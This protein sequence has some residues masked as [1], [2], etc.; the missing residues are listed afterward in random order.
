MSVYDLERVKLPVLTGTPLKLFTALLKAPLVGPPLL[1]KLVA[2][3]G[4][5]KLLKAQLSQEPTFRPLV[6]PNGPAPEGSVSEELPNATG[7][8][9]IRDYQRAYQS[10]EL[11]PSDVAEATLTAIQ[12]SDA[13][14]RPLRAII[15]CQA[16][17][18]RRQ[19]EAA[20]ERYKT[21]TPK[22]PLDG[23]PVAV[24]DEFNMLPYPTTVGTAFLGTAPATEDATV[25]KRLREAG[26]LLIG[27]ANMYEIGISPES[28]NMHHGVVRNPYNLAHQAG[29]SS[30]GPAAAVAAG[31][32]PMAL[33]ADG[34]G[35]IRVPASFCGVVGLKATYGRF[36][37]HG[38]APLCWT[39]AHAGPIAATT[40]DIALTYELTA[41][42]DP[43]DPSTQLQPPPQ[44]GNWATPD[45]QGVRLGVFRPWFEHAQPEI[46][47][48]CDSM[49]KQLQSAGAEVRE[50]EVPQLDLM[51]IAHAVT[52]LSEMATAMQPH[53]EHFNQH[54]PAVQVNLLAGREFQARHYVLAQ[55]VRTLALETFTQIYES[56][57]AVVTP[58]AAMTAPEIP[59]S[60]AVVGWSN[61]T[62]VTEIMRFIIAGNLT[63]LPA[64]SFPVG[65]D[66]TGLPIGMQAMANHWNEA[67]L[68]RLAWVAE[69]NF[70]RQ[71]PGLHYRHL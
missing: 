24:K 44:L 71:L 61:I 9:S 56:V 42:A 70:E 15:A 52:I 13:G 27:K 3:A 23:V 47:Q 53:A 18:V 57:H 7:M 55:K 66:Q 51:R 21:G 20:S 39:L 68:L 22:S 36:S 40:E 48:A 12:E 6:A 67:L 25:V 33:G 35:S 49:L 28:H 34:G 17:D 62:N 5:P 63:G 11:T 4:I 41:G 31:L 30:S 65:Y 64:I 1:N 29:G 38:A 10:G 60:S 8:A 58:T 54:A 32:C 37:E 14:E 59:E 26:A 69:Q 2:D 43:K 46:V 19:A 16:D 45:L 50:I